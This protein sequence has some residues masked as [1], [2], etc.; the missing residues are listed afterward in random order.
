MPLES[1]GTGNQ[2]GGAGQGRDG[3]ASSENPNVEQSTTVSGG[4][5]GEDVS[6]PRAG[7]K[8]SWDEIGGVNIQLEAA[9]LEIL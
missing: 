1:N 4:D 6:C 7:Q 8:R 2:A 9:V 3:A 5:R